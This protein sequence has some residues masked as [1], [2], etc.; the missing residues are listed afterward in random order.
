M[1][2]EP[3]AAKRGYRL[4]TRFLEHRPSPVGGLISE[5]A[6]L[7]ARDGIGLH[8]T[9][10]L[11]SYG[12]ESGFQRGTGYAASAILLENSK[13]GD[14]P[15]FLRAVF[16]DQRSVL[17]T[18]VDTRKLLFRTILAPPDWLSLGIDKDSMRASPLDEF[19]LLS[20]VPQPSRRPGRQPLVLRQ[21]ARP[22]KVH[23]PTKVPAILL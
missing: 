12:F 17:A 15:E 7:P 23:T 4:E 6:R 14:A 5:S 10:S 11:V 21:S 19:S 16:E 3:G 13:A 22:V 8:E 2:T 20:A 1:G 9:P 18:V